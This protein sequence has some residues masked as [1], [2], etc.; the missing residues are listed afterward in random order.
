MCCSAVVQVT[1]SSIQPRSCPH[2]AKHNTLHSKHLVP[3]ST[4]EEPGNLLV[5]ESLADVCLSKNTEVAAV[6][7]A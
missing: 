7:T 4:K 6:V 2:P 1:M 3:P 5:S